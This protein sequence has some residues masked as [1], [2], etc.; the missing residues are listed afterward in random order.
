[1]SEISVQM[2]GICYQT[3]LVLSCPPKNFSMELCW[4]SFS[5][6]L[7]SEGTHCS[8]SLISSLSQPMA[9]ESQNLLLNMCIR[10]KVCLFSGCCTRRQQT[11][12]AWSALWPA[13]SILLWRQTCPSN[14]QKNFSLFSFSSVPSLST[15]STWTLESPRWGATVRHDSRNNAISRRC[16]LVQGLSNWAGDTP[17][18]SNNSSRVT[19]D[20]VLW[21]QPEI[22]TALNL[23]LITTGN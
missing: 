15:C 9:K 17:T 21:N 13:L 3:R 14:I 8:A 18:S 1:M 11:C 2:S 10:K 6:A 4:P 16:S 12:S 22:Q 5:L 20:M 7:F 23:L 19:P